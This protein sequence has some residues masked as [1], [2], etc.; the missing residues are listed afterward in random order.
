MIIHGILAFWNVKESRHE[1]DH[2]IKSRKYNPMTDV[3]IW[4]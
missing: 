2:R 1:H 4:I 3:D